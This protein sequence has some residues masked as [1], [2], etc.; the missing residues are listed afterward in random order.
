MH[1]ISFTMKALQNYL[2]RNLQKFSVFRA[3]NGDMN[4][5]L[6]HK[7]TAIKSSK[8]SKNLPIEL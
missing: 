7:Y 3:Q 6:L 4:T 1:I 8:Q 2:N 5:K